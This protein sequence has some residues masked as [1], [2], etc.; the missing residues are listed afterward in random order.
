MKAAVYHR[1][2][3]PEVVSVVDVPTPAPRGDEL[4]VRV[5]AARVGSA[6]SVARQGKPYY[7]RAFFGV[8]RPKFP[9]L[10]SDFAGVVE[11][12]GPAV[13][14][15][16]V[17]DEVFGALAPRFGAH[18][19]YVCLSE[20][21]AVAPKPAGVSHAEA[22]ALV[23]ATALCFLRDKASV[24][25]GQ[26]VLVNGASGSVGTSAVQL[27]RHYGAT[28]TAVCHPTGF[29]LVQRLGADHVLDYAGDE[30]RGT[31]DVV[32]DV[33]GRSSFARCHALLNPGGVYLTTAPSPAIFVQMPWTKWIGKR[34]AVVAFAGLRP[35][36]D[37]ANDLRYLTELVEAGRLA[38]VVEAA[39]PLSKTADAYRHIEQG[40][41]RGNVV[42]TL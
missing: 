27:A 41:R 32:F 14:R 25:S 40:H 17:G 23:D 37:K 7:A 1:Y 42:V 31:Y 20:Q 19:E 15:Y 29:D 4:L 33:A 34:R 8:R 5:H 26:T 30:L 35:A 12:V 9:V 21:A 11:A 24:H 39:Y 6:D 22:A 2:G 10:G 3:P 18:A 13:T 38:P 28:V 36:A 16:A